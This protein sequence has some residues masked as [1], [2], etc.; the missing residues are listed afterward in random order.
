MNV[1]KVTNEDEEKFVELDLKASFI[2]I[3]CEILKIT[4]IY[5]FSTCVVGWALTPIWSIRN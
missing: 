2:G 5:F 4:G 3:Y 1:C